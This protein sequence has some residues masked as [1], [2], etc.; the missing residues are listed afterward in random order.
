MALAQAHSS[1]AVNHGQGSGADSFLW[2]TWILVMHLLSG[3]YVICVCDTN[4]AA[5]CRTL[6]LSTCQHD[7]EQQMQVSR[8]CKQACCHQYLLVSMMSNKQCNF[9][10]LASKHAVISI[11]LSA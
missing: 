3:R 2:L 1:S 9:C 10:I 8:S 11:Y 4:S 6:S 5:C 7:E